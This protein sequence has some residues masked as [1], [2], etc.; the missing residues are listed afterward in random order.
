MIGRA[1]GVDVSKFGLLVALFCLFEFWT[2]TRL[3]D[4]CLRLP[5][6]Q[7]KTPNLPFLSCAYQYLSWA[8]ILAGRHKAG[9]FRPTRMG[10]CPNHTNSVRTIFWEPSLASGCPFNGWRWTTL[11]MD[12]HWVQNLLQVE[13]QRFKNPKNSPVTSSGFHE[14]SEVKSSGHVVFEGCQR[15]SLVAWE[16]DEETFLKRFFWL[17]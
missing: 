13:M 4:H 12:H 16:V 9:V 17:R 3:S 1:N 8:W 2:P 6:A 11:R 5:N 7:G 14:L 15:S 10:Q